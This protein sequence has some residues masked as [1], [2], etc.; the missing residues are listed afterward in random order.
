MG[1]VCVGV[2]GGLDRAYNGLT[3]TGEWTL[4]CPACGPADEDVDDVRS[5][6]AACCVF[7]A[8]L[9]WM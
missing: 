6:V 9:L 2:M 1:V 4:L 8:E 5:G 3:G 7:W